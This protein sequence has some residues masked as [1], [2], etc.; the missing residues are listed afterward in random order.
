[1]LVGKLQ[2]IS[3]CTVT[4]MT[5][6]GRDVKTDITVVTG[7]TLDDSKLTAIHQDGGGRRPAVCTV[8]D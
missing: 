6:F 8:A 3:L 4:V 2:C 7:A 1:M 5:Q